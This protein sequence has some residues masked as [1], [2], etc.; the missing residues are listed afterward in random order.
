MDLS[1]DE[2][3]RL[4]QLIGFKDAS[5]IIMKNH[6]YAV[7]FLSGR[8]YDCVMV[9]DSSHLLGFRF[10]TVQEF[11]IDENGDISVCTIPISNSV[12]SYYIKDGIL[13]SMDSISENTEK[14]LKIKIINNNSIEVYS[15]KNDQTY[16]LRRDNG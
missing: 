16:E 2:Y 4:L 5:K 9:K 6:N 14:L 12:D 15:Y 10:D 1:E 7:K 3:A 8:W 11:I 13:Y